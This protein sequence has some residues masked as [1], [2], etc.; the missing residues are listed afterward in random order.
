MNPPMPPW[1]RR[2]TDYD[3]VALEFDGDAHRLVER[4]ADGYEPVENE[5]TE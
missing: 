1:E 2:Q 3:R 5:S 4:R